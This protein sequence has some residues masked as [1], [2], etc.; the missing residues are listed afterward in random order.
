MLICFHFFE[1]GTYHL[2][3]AITIKSDYVP[4]KGEKFT[5]QKEDREQEGEVIEVI[6][7]LDKQNLLSARISVE[8]K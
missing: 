4:R 2:V 3:D 8:F 1:I 7:L 6:H 5:L